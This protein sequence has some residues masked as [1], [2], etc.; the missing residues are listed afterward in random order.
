MSRWSGPGAG[1]PG[2]PGPDRRALPPEPSRFRTRDAS[3]PHRRSG[4]LDADGRLE[5]LGRADDQIKIRGVRVELE[6]V[7]QA[8]L[9]H[10][11]VHDAAV[12]AAGDPPVLAAYIEL[13]P[14]SEPARAQLAAHLKRRL[15]DAMLPSHILVEERL[16]RL[17]SG[18]G[19]S[20]RAGAAPFAPRPCRATDQRGASDRFH[21]GS[22]HRVSKARS[23]YTI[24]SLHWVDIRCTSRAFCRVFRNRAAWNCLSGLCSMR[25]RWRNWPRWWRKPGR[26]LARDPVTLCA[27]PLQLGR[28]KAGRA[29]WNMPQ[30]PQRRRSRLSNVRVGVRAGERS[31]RF[32]RLKNASGSLRNWNLTGRSTTAPTFCACKGRS[33]FRRCSRCS[34]NWRGGMRRC[35]PSLRL[36]TESPR[37]RV[38]PPAPV[39]VRVASLE[40]LA[41]DQFATALR[42][43]HAEAARPFEL[44]RGPLLRVLVLRLTPTEHWLSVCLHHI[45]A[46]DWTLGVLLHGLGQA[47]QAAT[48]GQPLP[49]IDAL[50]YGDFA[51]W[52][53]ERIRRGAL[54]A[55]R[56]YWRRQLA[57]CPAL[58]LP[59]DRP[60]PPVQAHAGEKQFLQ[61]EPHVARSLRAAAEREGGYCVRWI[62]GSFADLPV[63]PQ[64][65]VRFCHRHSGAGR[66]RQELESVTGFFANTL[67]LRQTVNS[68]DSG[69]DVLRRTRE[70]TIDALANQEWPFEQLVEDL[71]PERDL[72]YNPLFQV[73]LV[74]QQRPLERTCLPGLLLDPIDV[75]TGLRQVRSHLH[76][77]R[78]SRWRAVHF[79]RIRHGIA[80]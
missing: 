11:S 44:D 71:Q 62:P 31:S 16:P 45:V 46:D 68:T 75:V 72:S 42:L 64:W 9:S 55:Q 20:K 14:G 34:S 10:A 39:E 78:T 65:P 60:R 48:S 51:V 15:P 61:V 18:K 52:Q 23:E 13:A 25:P 58:H 24:T 33:I 77:D 50:Q 47:Y 80:G 36:R 26:N 54:D 17:A 59:T 70:T 19:R 40:A 56:D 38:Q 63:P 6:E 37:Q 76:G 69:I 28:N 66:T 8:L 5:F 32:R 49:V 12:V 43:A 21:L 74:Y 53:E 67:V 79:H 2:K 30:L 29:E 22:R 73:M 35:E 27:P 4:S 7:R 3:L 57:S 41:H 1:I